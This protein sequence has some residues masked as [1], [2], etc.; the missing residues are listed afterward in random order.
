MLIYEKLESDARL[1]DTFR[2]QV[3]GGWLV[4]VDADYGTGVT[5]FPDPNHE[6][7][8][9]SMGQGPRAKLITPVDN[10]AVPGEPAP[11]ADQVSA[12]AEGLI[13]QPPSAGEPPAG[14]APPFTPDQQG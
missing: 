10:A 12:G 9:S 8:G 5:F 7:D 13:V 2:A 4:A 3:P 14:G 1:F 11:A 6:W